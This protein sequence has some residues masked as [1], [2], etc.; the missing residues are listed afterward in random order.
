MSAR[1]REIG[2]PP[3]AP[4]LATLASGQPVL[5]EDGQDGRTDGTCLRQIRLKRTL[6]RLC[7][8][9]GLAR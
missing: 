3:T 1:A 7:L 4:L 2:R 5:T 9:F 8:R 6:T